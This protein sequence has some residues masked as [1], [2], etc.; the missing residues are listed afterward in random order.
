MTHMHTGFV[1]LIA[2]LLSQSVNSAELIALSP[3]QRD[4]LGI[5]TATLKP[6]SDVKSMSLPAL[7]VVPNDQLHII[8]TQQSGLITQLYVVEG[9]EVAM[10]QDLLKV[11][12]SDYLELQ[13]DYLQLLSRFNLVENSYN[14]ARTALNEGI[15]SEEKLLGI[16]SEFNELLA[17]RNQKREALK[18]SGL[19]PEELNELEKTR[20]LVS[21]FIIRSPIEGVVL[22]Q[23]ASAG[24]RVDAAT[25]IYKVGKLKP[26]WIEIHVP[27]PLIKN[28]QIGNAIH[29]PEYGVDGKIITIGKQI[30]DADQGIMIRAVVDEGAEKLRPGQFVQAQIMTEN[31]GSSVYFE[32]DKNA[33]IY[34]GNKSYVFVK[35]DNGFQPVEVT[36]ISRTGNS[37]VISGNLD[38]D[39]KI[40]VTGTSALKAI[41][42]G[43]G[44]ED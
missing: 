9:N 5:H 42:T 12:S 4:N 24:E 31:G 7:T 6:S 43:M 21:D 37:A 38:E 14:K 26:L 17:A 33:L 15:M 28:S 1:F 18:L 36:V 30:H 16:Q 3:Q 39:A 10:G 2:L 35:R 22:E 19:T 27:L 41:M 23:L 44:G 29:V 20:M 25:P 11:Q 13:R 32:A 34:T 40:A 8:S